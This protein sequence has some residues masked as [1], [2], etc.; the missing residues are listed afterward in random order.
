MRDDGP[1]QPDLSVEAIR[2]RAELRR[3]WLV[4][5][6]GDPVPWCRYCGQRIPSEWPHEQEAIEHNP[7][8][9][10]PRRWLPASPTSTRCSRRSTGSAAPPR[11]AS[12]S[13]AATAH[14][15]VE[16]LHA[17]ERCQVN[18]CEVEDA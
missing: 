13:R 12:R 1:W 15:T 5:K 3:L 7:S 16:F 14:M 18:Q 2:R 11:A 6:I 10:V 9:P 8:C 17:R 4:G